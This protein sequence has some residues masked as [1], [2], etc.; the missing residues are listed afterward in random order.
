M[1]SAPAEPQPWPLRR[2]GALIALIFGV[3]LGLIFWLSSAAPIRQAPAAAGLSLNLAGP[4]FAELRA[5]NDPTLF[6]L[7]HPQGFSGPVW[8]TMPA[9]TFHSYEWSAPTNRLLLALDQLGTVFSRLVEASDFTAPQLPVQPP[10]APTLPDLPPQT[11]LTGDSTQQLEGG[12]AQRRLLAPP[13]LK[14]WPNPDVLTS[15]VVQVFVD[16]EG[17][18]VSPPTLLSRSGSDEADADALKQARAAR[19]EP[20]NRE[21]VEGVPSP[22]VHLTW[23]R[24]IFRWHTIPAPPASTPAGNP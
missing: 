9:R 7:P 19:F 5:L 20:V 22:M 14:S 16:D 23:G 1:T 8:L 18:L 24:M 12:L 17:R 21:P 3:Q 6:A 4:D 13:E 10:A 2:W 15:S 11:L